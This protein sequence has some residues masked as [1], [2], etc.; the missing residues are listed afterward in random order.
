VRAGTKQHSDPTINQ[1]G[2]KHAPPEAPH[3]PAPP[4]TRITSFWVPSRAPLTS[5]SSR[6]ASRVA[7]L[8]HSHDARGDVMTGGGMSWC[9]CV[10]VQT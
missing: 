9:V 10:C 6:P 5:S 8:A 7:T 1:D 3:A 4:V 2:H